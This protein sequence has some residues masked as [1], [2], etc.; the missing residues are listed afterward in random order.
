MKLV[1][2]LVKGY[3]KIFCEFYD[4]KSGDNLNMLLEY[5]GVQD[6]SKL[7]ELD[8]I[9]FYQAEGEDLDNAIDICIEE[10]F[11]PHWSNENNIENYYIE[12][13]DYVEGDDSGYVQIS[14][15]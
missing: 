9:Q 1:E 6:G 14:V 11:M 13:I 4:V 15:E 5:M 7:F 2:K 10:E 12:N 3:K 8:G